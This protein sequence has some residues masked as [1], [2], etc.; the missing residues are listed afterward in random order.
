MN[1]LAHVL[2]SEN[3]IEHQLGNLLTDPLKGKAWD[4]ASERVLYGIQMHMRI[5]SKSK[6][7]LILSHFYLGKLAEKIG[8]E[9]DDL[10]SSKYKKSLSIHRG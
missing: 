7:R 3:H 9:E 8:I 2:L 1:W 6:A 5:D 10:S 4:G